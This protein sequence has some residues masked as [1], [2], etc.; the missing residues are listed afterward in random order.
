MTTWVV[1]SNF[2]NI[3]HLTDI[4]VALRELEIPFVD[5][6]VIP[7]SDDF[8]TP[9]DVQDPKIIPYGST[10]LIKN[11]MRR[12]WSGT[13]FDEKT[14]RADVWNQNRDDMLN[15]DAMFMT[16][17]EAATHF[18]GMPDE[19]VW[20]IR[21]IMDLKQFNGTVTTA[22][23]IKNWMG[24][25]DS[26]NFSFDENT[27]VAIAS[28]KNILME[29]RH[30]VVGGKIVTSSSYRFKGLPLTKRE[31]DAKVIAEAQ[32]L[33]DKWLPHETVVMDVALTNDGVKVIEFNC[34]N[35]S[36]FYYHNIKAFVQAATEY[37]TNR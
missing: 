34:F 21:P 20:F 8:V 24:S 10:S 16:V 2:L 29:W 30:F 5:V 33:A 28:P 26:G 15:Q 13:Y 25:V 17:K 7:F 32:A 1:Q 18:N 14:F 35:G 27:V 19:D 36:G 23:E 37:E 31:E 4:A 11:A 3:N 12:G 6:A 9:I 22:K